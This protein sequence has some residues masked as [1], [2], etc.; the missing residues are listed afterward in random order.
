MSVVGRVFSERRS[1]VL[2]VVAFLILN[3]LA[4]GAVFYLQGE[5]ESVKSQADEA[6]L[7]LGKAQLDERSAKGDLVSKDL[8]EK[9]L[10]KFYEDI[11]PRDYASAVKVTNF[12][13]GKTARAAQVNYRAGQYD[14][15]PVRDSR[16]SRVTGEITLLGDYAD[17]RRFLYEVET[18]QEFVIIEKVAL[19]QSSAIQGNTQLEVQLSIVTYFLSEPQAGVV[20]K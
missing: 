13:L 16:L 18:A 4:L 6:I 8:A 9:E 10:R 12:W 20:A 17:I 2:P 14:M 5:M 7:G 11:L 15:E 19:S 3:V 1:V